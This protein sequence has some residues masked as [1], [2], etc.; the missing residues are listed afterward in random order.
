M[1]AGA[2]EL[3]ETGLGLV[4]WLAVLGAS[5]AVIDRVWTETRSSY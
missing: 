1:I 3:T 5:I 2:D 4:V